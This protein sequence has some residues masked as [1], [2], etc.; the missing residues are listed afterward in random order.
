MAKWIHFQDSYAQ[1]TAHWIE[2]IWK[3]I[4]LNQN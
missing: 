1:Q 4:K 3:K 2:N